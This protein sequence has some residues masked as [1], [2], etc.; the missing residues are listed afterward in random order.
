MMSELPKR[1][2]VV[3]APA[4]F[5]KSSLAAAWAEKLE[6]SGNAVG[7]L[8][9]DSD[10]DEATRCL[11]YVSQ[12][13][14]HAWPNVGADAI[15]LILENNLIDPAAILSSLIND[16]AEI[17]DEAYL[18]LEDY[19]WI[20]DSRIHQTVHRADTGP[21]H[22]AVKRSP[23]GNRTDERVGFSPDDRDASVA[24][25]TLTF[26]IPRTSGRGEHPD[27]FPTNELKSSRDLPRWN[28]GHQLERAYPR[29]NSVLCP[30]TDKVVHGRSPE[31]QQAICS[32]G[33]L[34]RS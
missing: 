17:D 24:E 32:P 10:D 8:T 25:C 9:I 1:V 27:C 21:R 7:W 23:K 6:Q 13:L 3:K 34:L 31:L 16:L 15:E 4:G 5:G 30:A 14:H 18:F 26:E 12:A 29:H 33:Y 28:H 2:G 22:Y 19:H 11:F 20:N